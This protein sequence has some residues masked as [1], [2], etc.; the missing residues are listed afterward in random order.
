MTDAVPSF[1]VGRRHDLDWLRVFAFALL[2]FYHIG[3]FYVTWD[4]HIKSRFMSPAMEPLMRLVNPW[5]LTLL[6]FISGVALHFALNR[7]GPVSL[8]GKRL[9]RIGLPLVFG[10]FIV[11]APQAY[12]ELLAKGEIEPG[13]WGFYG[14]YLDFDFEFSILTPTW[15][16]L[17]YLA[18]LLIYS[19][20]ICLFARPLAAAAARLDNR[21]PGWVLLII[22]P[23]LFLIADSLLGARFPITHALVDD[24]Y[25]H[26]IS[27]TAMLFG[28]LVAMSPRFWMA[29]SRS[30]GWAATVVLALGAVIFARSVSADMQAIVPRGAVEP[31]RLIYGWMVILVLLGFAKRHCNRTGPSLV[32]LSGA[33]LPYYILHQTLIV[34]LGA[35][36]T[37]LRLPLGMELPFVLTGTLVG[38]AV[39]Y[40]LIRRSSLLRPIFGLAPERNVRTFQG[41]AFAVSPSKSA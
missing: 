32:Y 24:W 30:T 4:W 12:F 35:S 3:M 5:R 31:I 28:F 25:N 14:Q 41:R 19:L 29:V 17:W 33:M 8:A 11:V 6:F 15:N 23:A 10:F 37:T 36:S 2:I 39:G 27:F 21:I 13:F 7:T 26:A 38:C 40:E 20:L 22:P 9:A 16:H 1:P 34:C 18:Y